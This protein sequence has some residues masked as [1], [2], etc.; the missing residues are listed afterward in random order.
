MLGTRHATLHRG[1]HVVRPALQDPTFVTVYSEHSS[2][3]KV[4]KFSPNVKWVASGGEVVF[5]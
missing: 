5:L 3:V 2:P 1:F 4:A